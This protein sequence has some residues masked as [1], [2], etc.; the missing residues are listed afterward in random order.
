M[1]GLNFIQNQKTCK[2]I[3]KQRQQKCKLFSIMIYVLKIYFYTEKFLFRKLDQIQIL[4]TNLIQKIAY[5][6]ITLSLWQFQML[7]S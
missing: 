2:F 3:Y 6:S 7:K 5:I 4:D 1:L